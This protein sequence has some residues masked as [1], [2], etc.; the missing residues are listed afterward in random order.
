MKVIKL[1]LK[2]ILVVVLATMTIA[3]TSVMALPVSAASSSTSATSAKVTSKDYADD[4]YKTKADK[5]K[6][7]TA[8]KKAK[9]NMRKVGIIAESQAN[10]EFSSIRFAAEAYSNRFDYIDW[11]G[12]FIQWCFKQAGYKPLKT[13]VSSD[14]ESL[15]MAANKTYFTVNGT[16]RLSANC[17]FDKSFV[18]NVTKKNIAV[19]N[20]P[21]KVGGLLSFGNTNRLMGY[22]KAGKPIYYFSL[23]AIVTSVSTYG[24]T[25]VIGYVYGDSNTCTRYKTFTINTKT[26]KVSGLGDRII[27]SYS[28]Y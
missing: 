25:K 11:C 8:Y 19:K 26:G 4:T 14:P 22:T 27:M 15:G 6:K 24:D 23:P 17:P 12:Y 28:E 21:F 10:L 18:K 3:G 2:R 7:T 16:I 13:G 9:T 5:A 20:I 1:K